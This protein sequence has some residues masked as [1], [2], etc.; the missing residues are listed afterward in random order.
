MK[1]TGLQSDGRI[2]DRSIWIN[3]VS[4]LSTPLA[5]PLVYPRMVAIHNLGPK[6]W[7]CHLKLCDIF[8]NM[9]LK[10]P[11]NF[12]LIDRIRMN[13]LF[14]LW[15]RFLVIM[16][17]TTEFIFWRMVR[18]VWYIL[19]TRWIQISCNNCLAS[20]HRMKFLLRYFL[21]NPFGM[22]NFC[23]INGNSLCLNQ[24]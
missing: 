23:L 10:P 2:D 4:Y 8:S 15:F 20:P 1:S 19:G 3:Y 9:L 12:L 22:Y 11:G 18:T 24:N 7:I 21:S 14:L 16:L 13:H 17:M 6:V 5:I